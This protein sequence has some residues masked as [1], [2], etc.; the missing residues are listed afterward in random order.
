MYHQGLG[1][2]QDYAQALYWY[3]KAAAQGIA[4]AESNMGVIYEKGL[5]V[6]KDYP[7]AVAWY[8]AAANHGA[9]R[10]QYNL[11]ML[12]FSGRGVPL[13][14]VSA[15]TWL[16]RA[17][18]AGDPMAAQSLNALTAIM[19]PHQKLQALTQLA[20]PRD[21]SISTAQEQSLF[22]AAADTQ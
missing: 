9:S 8:I 3:S 2:Q 18:A 16:R 10:G 4:E 21:A 20:N 19:T 12:Y 5:G 11:G 22:I 15:Y 13:D 7:K 6:E 14:Y 17:A 1:V